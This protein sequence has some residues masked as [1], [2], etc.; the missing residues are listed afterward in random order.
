MES[1]LEEF[2]DI[3]FVREKT[4]YKSILFKTFYVSGGSAGDGRPVAWHAA[5]RCFWRRCRVHSCGQC[6]WVLKLCC[7]AV[8]A[9]Q[10][11]GTS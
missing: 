10:P 7:T 9:L 3:V 8:Y 4:N 2:G 5:R 11:A 1:E 6:E